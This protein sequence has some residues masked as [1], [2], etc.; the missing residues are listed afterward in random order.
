MKV[1][2]D[3]QHV[4]NTC[5]IYNIMHITGAGEFSE[6][7]CCPLQVFRIVSICLGSPPDTFCWEFRDKEKN[8]HKIGPVTPLEFYQEHVK[9]LF[10]MEDKVGEYRS[11]CLE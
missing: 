3:L 7:F 10:N 1:S 11:C 6:L 2:V 8:Y 5:Y 4:F 9:P